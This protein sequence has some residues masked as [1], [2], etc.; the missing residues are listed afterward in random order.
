MESLREEDGW[1]PLS[2]GHVS[3]QSGL[4]GPC[5]CARPGPPRSPC[6]A[7]HSTSGTYTHG[8][9]GN[10]GGVV[11]SATAHDT[12]SM[13]REVRLHLQPAVPRSLETGQGMLLNWHG[14]NAACF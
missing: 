8:L 11:A 1:Q 4:L 10:V 7:R 3:A 14:W 6:G 5:T 12:L 13:P 2:W 9:P